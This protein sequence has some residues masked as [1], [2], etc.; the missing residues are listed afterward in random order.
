MI[1]SRFV[2]L[3]VAVALG[4]IWASPGE[5]ANVACFDWT[6]D[7]SNNGSCTFNSSCTQLTQ[8]SLWRYSWDFGDGTGGLT[9]SAVIGH[10]Y[11]AAGTP[12]CNATVQLTVIPFSADS[13]SVQCQIMVRACVGPPIGLSGR[14]QGS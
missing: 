12:P 3:A 10:N 8:G 1:R 7:S 14:C 11:G 9:G 4:M 5:A 6:C 2:P 13:F